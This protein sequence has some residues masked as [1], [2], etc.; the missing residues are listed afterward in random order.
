MAL[1][2]KD[3]TFCNSNCAN[4]LCY[5]FMHKGLRKEA[6]EFGLPLALCDYSADCPDYIKK[7]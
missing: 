1:C 2:Y 6:A 3:K 5:R 7:E 4:T